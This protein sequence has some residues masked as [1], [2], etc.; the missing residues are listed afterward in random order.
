MPGASRQRLFHPLS[1]AAMALLSSLAFTSPLAAQPPPAPD[2]CDQQDSGERIRCRFGNIVAQQQAASDLIS[3]MP[4]VPENQREALRGQVER[5]GRAHGRTPASEFKQLTKKPAT[6]CQIL[7]IVGDGVGDD[8]GICKGGEDCVEVLGDQ[9]GD[10]DG[11]CKPRNG[12]N[13]EACVEICDAEAIAADPDNFDD[14][15][16]QDSVGRDVEEQ[17]D[18]ITGQYVELNRML[19]QEAQ[20]RAAASILS[21]TGE[22]CAAVVAARA[23]V[24]TFAFIVGL[25]DGTRMGAD[26]AERFCDQTAFGVNT[27]AVCSVIEG[28]AGA[29]KVAA[30]VFEFEDAAVDSDTIDESFACLKSLSTDVQGLGTDLQSLSADVQGVGAAVGDSNAALTSLQIQIDGLR[31]Q[32]GSLRQTVDLVQGEVTE[33]RRLVS[34]PLGQ[35]EGFPGGDTT[36]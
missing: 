7:E 9:I 12:R 30:T 25:A 23:N 22:P 26:I 34:T 31:Q 16:E 13:R 33:V 35:R 32:L 19:E 14:D 1:A 17:L 21:G 24:N 28:I 27:A 15:P 5:N 2:A 11:V 10:D 29:A 4:N 6:T 8:D 18:G 20:L 36:K 3:L